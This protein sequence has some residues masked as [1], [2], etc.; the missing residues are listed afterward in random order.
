VSSASWIFIGFVSVV[1]LRCRCTGTQGTP[2]A[3]APAVQ[4]HMAVRC[5]GARAV[6]STHLYRSASGQRCGRVNIPCEIDAIWNSAWLQCRCRIAVRGL[7]CCHRTAQR[8]NPRQGT[9]RLRCRTQHDG[10]RATKRT[11][12]SCAGSFRATWCRLPM[13]QPPLQLE[14]VQV[15]RIVIFGTIV[16]RTTSGA[17]R[18]P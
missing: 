2:A 3:T 11:A 10:A 9:R 5:A 18:T 14:Q 16:R 15:V 1:A 13:V 12:C 6:P 7:G 17:G 8:S 4:H